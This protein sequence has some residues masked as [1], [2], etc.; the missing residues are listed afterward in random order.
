MVKTHLGINSMSIQVDNG[1]S[2]RGI[3]NRLFGRAEKYERSPRGGNHANRR[4][5]DGS[6]ACEKG[7]TSS[8][9]KDV[10]KHF[11]PLWRVWA[12]EMGNGR[13]TAQQLIPVSSVT[14]SALK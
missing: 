3:L 14:S 11:A 7:H 10:A 1:A 9:A 5:Y 4:F 8:W 13:V 6:T 2:I 12:G